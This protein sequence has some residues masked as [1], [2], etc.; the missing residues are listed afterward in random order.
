V[1]AL[2]RADKIRESILY[3]EEENSSS[4]VNSEED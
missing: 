3:D 1:D 4:D 2:D